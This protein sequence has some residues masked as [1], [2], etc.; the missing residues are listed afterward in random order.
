MH[1][2]LILVGAARVLIEVAGYALLGQG[3][4]ALLAGEQRHANP[5]YRIL[6]I[7]TGP[8]IKAARFITP[9]FIIDA[10]IPILTFFLLFWL[11]IALA[12]AKRHLCGLHGVVC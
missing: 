2:D 1:I 3:V 10:H 6:A 5:F 12:L 9:R 11:W 4:L 8:T 7:I